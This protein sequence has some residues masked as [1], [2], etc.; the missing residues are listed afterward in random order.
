VTYQDYVSQRGKY[1]RKSSVSPETKAYVQWSKAKREA[2][3]KRPTPVEWA[4]NLLSIGNNISANTTENIMQS[5]RGQKVPF[6]EYM[7]D[8]LTSFT[9]EGE[10]SF[11]NVFWGDEEDSSYKG[12]FGSGGIKGNEGK[13]GSKAFRWATGT[14]ADIVLDPA[15]YVS[16]GAT[17]AAKA[18][19]SASAEMRMIA[20]AANPVI[21]FSLF[22]EGFDRDFLEKLSSAGKSKEAIAYAQKWAKDGTFA[23]EYS[24]YYREALRKSKDELKSEFLKALDKKPYNPQ[25]ELVNARI[26]GW[27]DTYDAA[28]SKRIEELTKKGDYSRYRHV[29]GASSERSLST[30][31]GNE[32]EALRKLLIDKTKGKKDFLTQNRSQIEDAAQEVVRKKL[33]GQKDVLA[34]IKNP[35]IRELFSGDKGLLSHLESSD[36]YSKIDLKAWDN[37]FS[38]LDHAGESAF[39]LFRKELSSNTHEGF[40]SAMKQWD[41]FKAALGSKQAPLSKK[42]TTYS[43]A[44]WSL[45]NTT[46]IGRVRRLLG[47]SNPYETMLKIKARDAAESSQYSIQKSVKEIKERLSGFS[48]ED[49]QE[50]VYLK[51]LKEKIGQRAKYA[52]MDFTTFI[53]ATADKVRAVTGQNIDITDENLEALSRL[54]K[55]VGSVFENLK[56]AEDVWASLGYSDEISS[57]PDYL[58]FVSQGAFKAPIGPGKKIGTASQAFTKTKKKGL[59]RSIEAQAGALR[60]IVDMPDEQITQLFADNVTSTNLALDEILSS[61]VIQHY[62]L[63]KRVDMIEAFKPFGIKL[64]EITVPSQHVDPFSRSHTKGEGFIAYSDEAGKDILASQREGRA[65]QKK[66]GLEEYSSLLG[67]E[68]VDDRYFSGYLFDEHVASIIDRTLKFSSNDPD[69]QALQNAFSGFT[70]LWKTTVTSNP[71]FHL[72]NFYSNMVTL[73]QQHGFDAIDPETAKDAGIAT[74]VSLNGVEKTAAQLGMQ[75]AL[76]RKALGKTYGDYT[77]GE[78][79]EYARKKGIISLS[80]GGRDTKEAV[81]DLLET[82]KKNILERVGK[83]SREA[84]AHIESF[85]KMDSFLIGAKRMAKEGS[86]S[87]SMLEY[88]KNESKKWFIDYEDLTDFEKN[89]LK[90]VFPFYTWLRRNIANQVGQMVA[91]ENWPTMALPQKLI[92]SVTDESVDMEKLPSYMREEGAVPLGRNDEDEIIFLY[93]QLPMNDLNKIPFRGG[94]SLKESLGNSFDS[95]ISTM[96]DS[97]HPFIKAGLSLYDYA[98]KDDRDKRTKETSGVAEDMALAVTDSVLRLFGEKAAERGENGRLLVD[99]NVLE[100]IRAVAPQI[101]MIDRLLSLPKSATSVL[102]IDTDV[103]LSEVGKQKTAGDKTK[104]LWNALS[105]YAGIRVTNVD[106]REERYKRAQ[107]IYYSALDEKT[108]AEK[109]SAGYKSRSLNSRRQME[110]TYRRLKLL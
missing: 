27:A 101:R 67:L 44:W 12:M 33:S 75:E 26:S 86:I 94:A 108:K 58:T 102:N 47:F 40:N 66:M 49:K 52:D 3:E 24:R 59:F 97:A 30:V 81:V 7:K 63:S 48:D 60:D 54:D 14:L 104:A 103:L 74:L 84:G 105:F 90:K 61:R 62:K 2:D 41:A 28:L 34:G 70:H 98:R 83:V 50:Y 92:K 65:A 43:D 78:L 91:I 17:N 8:I 107:G 42:G 85:A 36:L 80:F 76:V 56:Q 6:S 69:I 53:R 38:V 77:L 22:R 82:G 20:R 72:R 64:D 51:S 1:G 93:P 10:K 11:R 35:R 15:N 45:M 5:F 25:G 31:I 89:T 37:P 88:A 4:L 18:A 96:I 32:S 39:K 9:P 23:K 16:F 13:P 68:E 21:D 29:K 110:K 100:A 95:F 87:P 19:A 99:S 46:A 57:L 106:E 109:K 71:G 73:F 55:E 79:A